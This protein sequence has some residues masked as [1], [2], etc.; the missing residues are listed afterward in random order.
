MRFAEST[1]SLTIC[2]RSTLPAFRKSRTQPLKSRVPSKQ[3]IVIGGGIAGLLA[4][5]VLLNHFEQ[6]TLLERDQYPREPVFRPGVPQ[7]RQIH[8]L[9]LRGQLIL[10]RMFPGIQTKLLS[11]GAIKQD[12]ASDAML[13]CKK[14][15]ISNPL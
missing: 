15:A 11:N 6:V 3:A 4:A 2:C 10:E 12:Y 7:G 14:P 5:R 13:F 1:C 9:L 8:T